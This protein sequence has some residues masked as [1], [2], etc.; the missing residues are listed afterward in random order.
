[1]DRVFGL[2]IGFAVAALLP[3]VAGAQ[4]G[5]R[6]PLA[7]CGDTVAA[8][9]GGDISGQGTCLAA[10]NELLAGTDTANADLG[11][12]AA[13]LGEMYR[14]DGGACMTSSTDLPGALLAVAA[15]STDPQQQAQIVRVAETVA[16]CDAELVTGSIGTRRALLLPGD[17][18]ARTLAAGNGRRA[19]E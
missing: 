14:Y 19:S 7:V 16:T 3:S 11:E 13:S 18:L 10:V 6:Q 15:A 4:S 12:L 1:M 5:L 2:C 8:Q 17:D 9:Y